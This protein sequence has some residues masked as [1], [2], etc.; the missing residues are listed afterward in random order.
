MSVF[1]RRDASDVTKLIMRTV[2]IS[3]NYRPRWWW[4]L[5]WTSRPKLG[6][7]QRWTPYYGRTRQS[8]VETRSWKH[9]MDV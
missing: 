6:L 2:E 8:G 1:K 4:N 3:L 5:T 7:V 9:D